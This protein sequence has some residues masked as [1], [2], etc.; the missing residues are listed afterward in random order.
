MENPDVTYHQSVEHFYTLPQDPSIVMGWPPESYGMAFGEIIPVR[1]FQLLPLSRRFKRLKY[2]YLRHRVQ[3]QRSLRCSLRRNLQAP[4]ESAPAVP[5]QPQPS[6]Q[7]SVQPSA[8]PQAPIESA[9]AVPV[10]A[11]P[12]PEADA[13]SEIQEIP[14]VPE[15]AQV[16][17]ALAPPKAPAESPRVPLAQGSP[18][19]EPWSWRA[20]S[21]SR[22]YT[23]TLSKQCESS[24]SGPDGPGGGGPEKLGN[25]PN[26]RLNLRPNLAEPERQPEPGA[27]VPKNLSAEPERAARPRIGSR[28]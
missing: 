17:R 28:D 12:A 4:I 23:L 25:S 20:T 2:H 5:A 18:A 24:P 22:F 11:V 27:A 19:A 1:V 8:Q 10:M 21:F 3:S 7:P 26:L 15:G 9:P 16:P 6:V 14:S 13:L